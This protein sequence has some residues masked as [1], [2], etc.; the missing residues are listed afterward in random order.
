MLLRGSQSSCNVH[1]MAGIGH[2]SASEG[3][4]LRVLEAQRLEEQGRRDVTFFVTYR[5]HFIKYRNTS[6]IQSYCR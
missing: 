3:R 1:E 6:F 4:E 5:Y 2:E